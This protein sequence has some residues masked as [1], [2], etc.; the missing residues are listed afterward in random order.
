MIIKVLMAAVVFVL[1]VFIKTFLKCLLGINGKW[2]VTERILLSMIEC[3]FWGGYW[4]CIVPWLKEL[5]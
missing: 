2:S 5:L 4:L 1:L 3:L